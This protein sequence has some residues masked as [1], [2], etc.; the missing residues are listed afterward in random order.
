MSAK[1]TSIDKI[2]KK[3]KEI[4]IHLFRVWQGEEQLDFE[5]IGAPLIGDSWLTIRTLGREVHF[6]ITHIDRFEVT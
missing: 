1:L 6:N 3:D 4:D 5:I 2:P